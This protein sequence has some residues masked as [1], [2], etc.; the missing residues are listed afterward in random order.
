MLNARSEDPSGLHLS[1]HVM[2]RASLELGGFGSENLGVKY[3][4]PALGEQVGASLR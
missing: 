3:I 4:Q 1:Y 2:E